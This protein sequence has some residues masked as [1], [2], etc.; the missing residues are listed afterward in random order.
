MNSRIAKSVLAENPCDCVLF[1]RIPCRHD[2]GM[3]GSETIP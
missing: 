3:Q 2:F 1:L